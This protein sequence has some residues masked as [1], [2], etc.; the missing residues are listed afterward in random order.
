MVR[1][2]RTVT[3]GRTSLKD[4]PLCKTFRFKSEDLLYPERGETPENTPDRKLRDRARS[5]GAE[6]YRH[7]WTN[8]V[9]PRG[10]QTWSVYYHFT[11]AY[12]NDPHKIS[13]PKP[14]YTEG[15]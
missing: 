10:R 3:F 1:S 14:K 12:I 13:G 11:H 15:G 8:N 5:R 4:T 9:G 6:R 7:W 2:W